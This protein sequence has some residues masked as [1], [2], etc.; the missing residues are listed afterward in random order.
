MLLN[1]YSHVV[2]KDMDTLFNIF[3]KYQCSLCNKKFRR[4]EESMQHE[5]VIHGS[6]RSYYC[7]K[8]NQNFSGME[9]MRDHIK[10]NHQ[11]KKKVILNESYR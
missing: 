5:Q 7:K 8:C 9:Q 6:G 11:Y 3:K 4:I 1:I 2:L 10:R